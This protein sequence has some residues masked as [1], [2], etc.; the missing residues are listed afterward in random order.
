MDEKTAEQDPGETVVD[1]SEGLPEDT[2]IQDV[3]E[4]ANAPVESEDIEAGDSVLKFADRI[5]KQKW[6]FTDQTK[7][8]IM[9]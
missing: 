7:G 6:N 5:Q 2:Q 3:S 9:V 1:R 8:K 4:Q